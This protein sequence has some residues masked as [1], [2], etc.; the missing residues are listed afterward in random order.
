VNGEWEQGVGADLT[1]LPAEGVRG[2]VRGYVADAGIDFV[3]YSSSAHREM[4]FLAFA[5]DA[6][7]AIVEEAHSAGLT[8]QACVLTPEAVK[9]AVGA[10]VDILQHADISGRHRL[11]DETV[12]LLA[13]RQVGAVLLLYTERYLDSLRAS[14]ATHYGHDWTTVSLVQ[15]ENA[16]R[17]VAARANVMFAT[18]GAVFGPTVGTSPWLG[19]HAERPDPPFKLGVSHVH[20]Q[21]AAVE[22]GLSPLEALQ[23][24]TRNIADAYARHDIGTLEVGKRADL[25][26]LDADPLQDAANYARVAGVWKDGRRVERERL[27]VQPVLTR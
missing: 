6:Q 8:A 20:W 9:V 22:H 7:R 26:L 15:H 25:V 1:W 4:R 2:R 5:P 3:K 10:G 27:P 16:Q 11:P 19:L 18:D 14:A 17:L 21:R 12:A 23:A 13:E 24:A